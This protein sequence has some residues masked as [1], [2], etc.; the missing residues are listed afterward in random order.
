MRKGY[1]ICEKMNEYLVIFDHAMHPSPSQVFNSALPIIFSRRSK[2][3]PDFLRVNCIIVGNN[4]FK[5]C[6]K[7]WKFSQCKCFN[8][9][10][11]CITFKLA[12]IS[13]SH[14]KF[15]YITIWRLLAGK[16][17]RG[18][19]PNTK[20]AYTVFF[21]HFLERRKEKNNNN[22]PMHCVYCWKS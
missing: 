7:N 12:Y 20:I 4:Y 18:K 3:A 14:N 15:N 22:G 2:I 9:P 16:L 13:H 10:L 8:K 6:N 17:F 21:F 1:L 5:T 19:K 11:R